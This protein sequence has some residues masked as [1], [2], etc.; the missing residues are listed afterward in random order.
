[1]NTFTKIQSNPAFPS[2]DMIWRQFWST[3]IIMPIQEVNTRYFIPLKLCLQ[4]K[5]LTDY[6]LL[7][8]S[9]VK[10]GCLRASRAVDLS[11]GSY[12]SSPCSRCMRSPAEWS[13]CCII[14]FCNRKSTSHFYSCR[15][16][17]LKTSA[18]YIKCKTKQWQTWRRGNFKTALML[19]LEAA[20][21]G[22]SNLPFLT[23]FSACRLKS[24]S[25]VI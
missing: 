4:T 14:K 2:W 1:M 23:Y 9:L 10:N 21:S 17:K 24:Q 7:R 25:N 18:K 6:H 3:S 19:S 20:P 13:T 5:L 16:N 11:D 15:P 8:L 12:L 22:Q